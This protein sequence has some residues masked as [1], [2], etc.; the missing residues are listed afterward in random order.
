MEKMP[1]IHEKVSPPKNPYSKV[2]MQT[3]RVS[4]ARF[5]RETP[6]EGPW[7]FLSTD[8]FPNSR[9]ETVGF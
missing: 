8:F 3:A 5:A 4:R 1:K 7:A 9:N 6:V 2:P